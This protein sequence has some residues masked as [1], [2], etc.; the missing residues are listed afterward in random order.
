MTADDTLTIAECETI[1]QHGAEA[2]DSLAAQDP[3]S[4]TT[5]AAL[6]ALTVCWDAR[7]VLVAIRD[8]P[9]FAA[10]YNA[11]MRPAGR[12]DKTIKLAFLHLARVHMFDHDQ[13]IFTA[14]KSMIEIV[15]CSRLNQQA[16][17]LAATLIARQQ[18]EDTDTED[19]G[20][21]H[22]TANHEL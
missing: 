14:A 19:N 17:H 6:F 13:R 10:A 8:I 22:P 3:E 15:K 1:C 12:P 21:S 18:L 16:R 7:N 4:V 5:G 11:T 2:Y 9:E 20:P